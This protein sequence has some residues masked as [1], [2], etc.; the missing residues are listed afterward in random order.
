MGDW[1]LQQVYPD[2][3]KEI[4][5]LESRRDFSE[6]GEAMVE[7]LKENSKIKPIR[8]L[9]LRDPLQDE[10]RANIVMWMFGK[11]VVPDERTVRRLVEKL[12]Q[13]V[14]P[15]GVLIIAEEGTK[16]GFEHVRLI[17]DMVL[18][19]YRTPRKKT[20]AQP[21]IQGESVSTITNAT[22][23]RQSL[24]SDDEPASLIFEVEKPPHQSDAVGPNAAVILAPCGTTY[25]HVGI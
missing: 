14:L 12:W 6:A 4:R 8:M 10:A 13:S 1:A 11:E 23:L 16:E 21:A 7:H 2:V 19:K 18:D 9:R 20:K 25:L 15:G 5:W 17:R 22:K 24:E 3:Q